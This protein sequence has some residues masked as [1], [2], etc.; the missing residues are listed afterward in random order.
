MTTR[1]SHS[2]R[3]PRRAAIALLAMTHGL[4][5]AVLLTPK[6]VSAQ[7]DSTVVQD[8]LYNRPFIG[9]VSSTSIGGYLEGNTNYFVEDGV[10]E[11]FSMELRRFNVF[12]FSQ[13]SQRVRFISELE[14][15]HGTEEIALE[16]ALIDLQINPGL[17]LRG[18][19]VLV[20]IGY[21]NVNHDSPRWDFIERPLVTTDIIPST[22]SE[23]GFGGHGRFDSGRLVLTWDAYLTNG[24][25]GGVVANETGRTS[26]PAG[27]GE[28]LFAEDNN[29]SPA[30]SGRI[31]VRQ[32]DVGEIGVSYYGGYYNDF[33]IE[34]VDVEQKRWAGIAA[35]DFGGSLGP[36]TIQSEVAVATVDVPPGLTELHGSSQWGGYV[37]AVM[38]VWRPRIGGYADAAVSVALRLEAVDYNRGTFG[39]TSEAI[40]DE[41][42]ALVPGLSVRP[43]SSTVFRANYR[44]HWVTDFQ[45]ND[46]ARV[47]GFQFGFATYF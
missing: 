35:V 7:T 34:G 12:L 19:I 14:F 15:E 4:G 13:V 21:L 47:A 33:R 9:S 2:F 17:V 38:P 43:S 6:P 44:Y 26:L 8:G 32:L 37:D 40:G 16:T 28:G 29:G 45:G 27:K 25:N 3:S 11:G 30:I 36:V 5:G 39:S 31:G 20:P 41:V 22:L 18:G 24:L 10:T 23:V 1:R 42:R 46:P